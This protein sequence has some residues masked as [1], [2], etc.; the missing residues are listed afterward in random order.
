[1]QINRYRVR[2]PHAGTEGEPLIVH[3]GDRLR[4]EH[5]ETAWPGWIWCTA[6]SGKTAWVP[7]SWTLMEDDVCIM[8]RDYSARELTVAE[9]EAFTGALIE[10]GWIWGTDERGRIGWVPRRCL[11][12]VED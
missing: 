10:S 7:E 12:A 3:R 4:F 9:G 6:D 1:M 5:R 8:R 11:E 2:E